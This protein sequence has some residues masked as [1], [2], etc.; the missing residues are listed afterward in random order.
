MNKNP[1]T[2]I[3]RSK[4]GSLMARSFRNARFLI[5]F[6][7]VVSLMCPHLSF[8]KRERATKKTEET[9]TTKKSKP[10]QTSQ[11]AQTQQVSQSALQCDAQSAL[12][13]DGLTG[14]ILYEQNSHLRIPPASFVKVMTLYVVFDAIRSGQLKRDDMVIVSEKAWKTQGSKMFIKV[15]DK[16]KVEDL[17]KG[18]AVASGNDA[19]IALAEHLAGS[20]EVFVSK[21]NEKAKLLGMKDSQFRNSDGMPAEGQYVS[22]L[23]MAILVTALYPGSS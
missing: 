22:A 15:G 16:V 21:M 1:T 9:Q 12:L 8:A 13:M 17:L 11:P 19:C 5:L 18:V 4:G 14:E 2:P 20:E 10:V 7:V 23:D 6:F 3:T